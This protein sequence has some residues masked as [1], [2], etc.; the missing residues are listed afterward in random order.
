MSAEHVAESSINL[1]IR[2]DR[3]D[4]FSDLVNGTTICRNL[5]LF[6]EH[7]RFPLG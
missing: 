4:L 1:S 6:L 3:R 7:T 2:H 5:K